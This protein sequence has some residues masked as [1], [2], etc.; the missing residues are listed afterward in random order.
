MTQQIIDKVYHTKSLI[1]DMKVSNVEKWVFS[2]KKH[3]QFL[4]LI[5]VN[6][7]DNEQAKEII[8]EIDYYFNK[9]MKVCIENGVMHDD[10]SQSE[11]VYQYPYLIGKSLKILKQDT[12]IFKF[13]D[14]QRIIF[15]DYL[16]RAIIIFLSCGQ[17]R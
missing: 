10:F 6:R 13:N 3:P 11:Y 9:P 4:S 15:N 1:K 17:G 16:N 12:S 7:L 5:E 2:L 8:R 14:E